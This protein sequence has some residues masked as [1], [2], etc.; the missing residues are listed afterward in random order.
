MHCFRPSFLLLLALPACQSSGQ[1]PIVIAEESTAVVASPTT[2]A[3]LSIWGS[4]DT[5]DTGN[6]EAI[7]TL[8]RFFEQKMR[9][10][11]IQ[12]YWVSSDPA[13]G[14]LAFTDIV[15]A[16]YDEKGEQK[17]LPTLMGITPVN[18]SDRLLTVKWAA[19]DSTG[20][21]ADVRYVFDFLAH[22]TDVGMRLDRPLEHNTRNWQR[23]DFGE[24][25][26]I[27]SPL[28][29][30]RQEQ[31]QEQAQDVHRLS[32][33]FGIDMFPITYYSFKDPADLFRA[34]GFQLHPLMFVHETGGIADYGDRVFSGND[35]DNYTHEIVHLFTT[36]K[37]GAE[38]PDMM[39]EGLATLLGG[40][41]GKPYAW[42]RENLRQFLKENHAFDPAGQT[43]M[44]DQFFINKETNVPYAIGAVVCE[45]ILRIAGKDGLFKVMASG[46]D[47]WPA[48]VE[49]GVVKV[50]LGAL[51]RNE[52][53]LPMLVLE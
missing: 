20:T 4:V 26:Y 53:D 13:P 46:T 8:R 1:D 50:D 19:T 23:E 38:R 39:D 36:R 7:A 12:S 5:L 42:H 2:Y 51:V 49:F 37:F 32:R 9:S 29:T 27:I 11:D 14:R 28:H 47:P 17:Y 43:N 24:L 40:S 33:F 15:Y 34:R 30:F 21:A 48:L 52:L 31:A 18:D 45:H 22:R 3:D 6:E 35:R 25:H 41:S 10:D 16:E 44:Y